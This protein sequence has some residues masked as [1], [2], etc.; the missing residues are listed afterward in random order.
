VPHADGHPRAWIRLAAAGWVLSGVAG[1]VCAV[2]WLVAFPAPVVDV[3]LAV[4]LVGAATVAVGAYRQGRGQ[5][6]GVSRNLPISP[7]TSAA[8]VDRDAAASC[9]VRALVDVASVDVAI[10]ATLPTI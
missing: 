5:D 8:I 6:A 1:L 3:A 2:S 4:V 9:V 7:S 10:P